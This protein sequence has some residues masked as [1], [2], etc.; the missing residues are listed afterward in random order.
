MAKIDRVTVDKI[1]DATNIVDVVS[2]FVSLK[3][4]GSSYLGLCPFHNERTPSFSVSPS[5]GI[6]KCFSCGKAGTAVSF[7]MDLE[8]MNY[9][10]ALK[11]L[12]RK[13]NIEIKERELTSEEKEADAARER[14]FAVNEFALRYFEETLA[15]TEDGRAIGLSYFRERG[16]SDAMIKRFHL[17]Y[18]QDRPDDLY[19]KAI[20]AGFTE[21]H[22][23]ET[24][25]AIKTERGTLYDR[26][27]GRVIYPVHSLSGRVVAFGGRTLRKEKTVAKYVNS[28]ESLIYSKSRELYGMY[29][30]RTAIAK[31]K[32]CILVEG[33]MDVISM[34][35]AGVENVVASSGTSLTD[36]QIRMIKRFAD[37]VTLIYDS[38]AAGIKASLRGINMLIAAGLSLRVV[39]L[40]EGD[41]PDSFAQNHSSGEVEAYIE[42]HRQDL[43]GFKV[44]VLMKD[45][46]SDPRAR[47]EAINDILQ[48][49]AIIPDVVEQSLYLDECARKVGVDV[50]ALSAQLKRFVAKNAETAY[51]RRQADKARESISDIAGSAS[52]QRS[53]ADG[54]PPVEPPVD[55]AGEKELKSPPVQSA[56]SVHVSRAVYLAEEEVIR[57]VLRRG[58]L[59]MCDV[60]R[61]DDD[62]ELVPMSVVD[63]VEYEFRFDN[64][65]FSHEPFAEIWRQTLWLRDNAWPAEWA[66][67][68]RELLERRATALALGQ[69]DI[70]AR[71]V[72]M[73]TIDKLEKALVERLDKEFNAGVDEFA[74]S[75]V[76]R[77]LLRSD[78]REL[79]DLVARLT[80]D[81]VVLSR[82]Y[83]KVDPRADAC[84][85]LP[86]AVNTL[87]SV[88]LKEELQC[89]T[90]ELG[91]PHGEDEIMELMIRYRKLKEISMEF[92]KF[93]GE[94]VI[95]P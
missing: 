46:G 45:A 15:D 19:K 4:R 20:A 10:E 60:L 85:K 64:I 11:W 87:K 52:S 73:D 30:A 21:R 68:E 43:I 7:L 23:V 61:H 3:K 18:A 89:I 47:S 13:Y 2:D 71:G 5:R 1:L 44:D 51:N 41:D 26:F 12:A 31:K 63:Y 57:Y 65:T 94:I 29:Q 55:M 66:A 62:K 34:H 69:E 77:H 25:L 93:T 9:T 22:L 79:T 76:R 88:L 17:G 80:S 75:F 40:P 49:I 70:R 78:N 84:R 95:M 16:I 6:F 92:D 54:I 81:S 53:S 14:M 8:S 28:P 83:P 27:K 86:L 50:S 33:Y 35:Q 74:S 56:Q 72:D 58:L 38:D 39:L 42:E 32:D 91:K 48:T 59:Y 82:M 24:G 90:A 67:R 36:G 37:S